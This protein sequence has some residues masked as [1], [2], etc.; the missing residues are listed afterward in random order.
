L[1]SAMVPYTHSGASAVATT[2]QAKLRE[3]VSVKDFGAVGDGATDDAT[4]IQAALDTGYDVLFDKKTYAIGSCL[5]MD[6]IGTRI[7]GVNAASTKILATHTDDPAIQITTRLCGIENVTITADNTRNAAAVT[8]DCYGIAIGGT[9]SNSLTETTIRKV[10]VTRQPSHGIYMG[11]YGRGT[12]FEQVSSQYNRGH[13][14]MFD[15]GTLIVD[16]TPV[17]NGIVRVINCS[18]TE[19]GGN[20]INLSQADLTCYRFVID[21]FECVDNAWNTAIASLVDTQ[22]YV[23]GQNIRIDNCGIGDAGYADTTMGNGDS[24]L[25]KAAAGNAIDIGDSSDSIL[26]RNNR[27][28]DVTMSVNAGDSL[29]GLLIESNYISGNQAVFVTL[30]TGA[31]GTYIS[32]PLDSAITS[33]PLVSGTTGGRLIVENYEYR[34]YATT[35]HFLLNGSLPQTVAS[36]AFNA[37]ST[38]SVLTGQGDVADSISTVSF[39]GAGNKLPDGEIVR[40]LNLN[41]YDLTFTHGVGNIYTKTGASVVVGQDE[42]ITFVAYDDKVYEV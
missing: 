22:F 31:T 8:T 28:I 33:T 14:F 16:G 26:I 3:S 30:G 18:G 7:I 38:L 20:A 6:V 11:G 13:G 21:N 40:C 36:G 15:D 4:A 17:R 1:T 27:F 34:I 24:R 42:G 5:T 25:G 9:A 2:V 37:R 23:K 19:N 39:S 12:I 32:I 29:K 35:S 10:T 41:V